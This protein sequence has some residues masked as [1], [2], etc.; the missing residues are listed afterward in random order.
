MRIGE[1]AERAGVSTKAVRYY[2]EL[3]LLG[4]ER[5][6]NGYREYTEHDLRVVTEIR[7][8][9]VQGIPPG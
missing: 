5:R 2:E 9:A 4:P 6:A 3:T 1:L 7:E 8:L